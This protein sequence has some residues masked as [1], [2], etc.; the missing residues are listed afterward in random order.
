VVPESLLIIFLIKSKTNLLE[1][2]DIKTNTMAVVLLTEKA[3]ALFIYE[4]FVSRNKTRQLKC[5]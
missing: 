4:I 5:E 3:G 1:K 2:L